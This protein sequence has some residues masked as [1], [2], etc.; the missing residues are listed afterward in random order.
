M[1]PTPCNGNEPLA[2]C[3]KP[4]GAFLHGADNLVITGT[5]AKIPGQVKANLLFSG[6]WV[7]LQQR[8]RGDDK[9]RRADAALKR[10]PFEEALLNRMQMGSV[11]NAFDGLHF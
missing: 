3:C 9:A 8:F 1:V 2:L 7:F 4:L 5:P 10:G 6:L 11:G